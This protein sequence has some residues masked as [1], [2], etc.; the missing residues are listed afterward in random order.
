MEKIKQTNFISNTWVTLIIYKQHS[1]APK[2][3]QMAAKLNTEHYLVLL[4][5]Q[6]MYAFT[7]PNNMHPLNE[8]VFDAQLQ[9]VVQV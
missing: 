6:C 7:I 8:L 5:K 3:R 2:Q 1:F 9:F 4:M